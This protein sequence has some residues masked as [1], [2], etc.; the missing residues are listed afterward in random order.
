M[1]EKLVLDWNE[2]LE[3][4]AAAAA[5]GCV[6]L[7]N[8]NGALPLGKDCTVSVFGRIQLN[9]Y[10]SGTGSGGMVNV[11]GVTGIL[12]GLRESGRV[13]INDEL[14]KIYEEWEKSNPYDRGRGWG[15]EPWSQKEMPLDN[16]TVRSAAEKSSAAIVI[17]GRTA[18]EDMDA[19]EEKGSYYLTDIEEDMLEKVC[20]SF[21]RTIVVLNT[22]GIIDMSF[23]KKYDPSAVL[24]VWHGGMAGGTGVADILTGKVSP[25]GKL[26]DTIAVSIKDYPSYENFGGDE[27]NFYKEDIYV[28]YRYFETFAKDKVLYPFGFGLSYTDFEVKTVDKGLSADKIRLAVSVKNIGRASGK[29]TVQ[30]YAEAP[31]GKLGKPLRSLV[32]FRKTDCL[33]PGDEQILYFDIDCSYLASYDDSGA[34]GNKSCYVLEAGMYNIY[35]G[36]D[37]RT[38]VK[39]ASVHLSELVV[40][41]RLSEA[42]AP[43]TAFERIKPQLDGSGTVTAVYEAVP[44]ATVDMD[45]RRAENIPPE[46]F[47]SGD[48]GIKLADVLDG[49]RTMTDFIAQLSDEDLSC[50]IRGEGMGSPKVTPG[51]ASAFGGISDRL[52]K[53]GIP[54][55]CCDDGPSGMR[56]DCGTKAF[57]LPSGTLIACTFD[58]LLIEKLF[59]F[60]GI[61][62]NVQRVDCLLGP[63]M[64]IHRHPLNGRNF[65]YFS[66]DPYLTGIMASAE[67][68]GL[69]RYGVTGTI[70]HFCGNNQE[71]NRHFTD[72]IV[73]ERAL[74]EIYLR[75]FEMAVKLGGAASVMT[76]YGSLNGL[77]TAG[78]YDLN[79]E[80]LRNEWGF[81][82]IVMTDWFAQINE[83]GKPA[84]KT[85]FAAMARSGN[86]LYMVVPDASYNS[87]GD[88]TLEA[89]EDG[90][91]SR[92]ELQRNAMAI[93]GFLMN[94]RAMDRLLG[95]AP[96]IEILNRPE[97]DGECE[98]AEVEYVP[99]DNVITVPLDKG[100]TYGGV[101]IVLGF[102]LK[103]PGKY[104]VTLTASSE[105]NE[106]A[107]LPCTLFHVGIP[108]ASFAF[109]GSGGK[110][111]SIE[112]TVILNKRF[113]VIRLN[114]AQNGLKLKSLKLE[115]QTRLEDIPKEEIFWV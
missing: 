41:E 97:E 85:N 83:R 68:S 22:A 50:I 42:L 65:E 33:A 75:G 69:H 100:E 32:S 17:I 98:P 31:Q 93:C 16:E 82:G 26:S 1:P 45:K 59:S 52:K 20:R 3:T 62:M 2:Y 38:A 72:T 13:K 107:Q 86:D 67:L 104:L 111:V 12:D 27:R 112:R 105:L 54:A 6:L 109:T 87:A 40:T 114:V 64:N 7:K 56:L 77:W 28:G 73:S 76:T 74:R 61:E 30:I 101:N 15:G 23:V 84:D 48:R 8:D 108:V 44:T 5:E 14:V 102:E 34:A 79:T 47:R 110:D 43:V 53:F 113:T 89:L 49:S 58:P 10:K 60:T 70:K 95:T 115:L 78:S 51:T 81:E 106:L 63:G 35:V 21:D 18:G 66:E 88:N 90:R 24:C 71:H 29:E 19:L 94:S 39:S 4:A 57:C 46:I 55:G 36:T 9:Y 99:A 11:S 96:E 103:N 37:V 92:G 91:I 25:C 80:I